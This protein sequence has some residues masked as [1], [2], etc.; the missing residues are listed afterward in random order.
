MKVLKK[1]GLMLFLIA[2]L[3]VTLT[4]GIV[5]ALPAR[6]ASAEEGSGFTPEHT[7]TVMTEKALK[8]A[9]AAAGETPTLIKLGAN[10]EMNSITS[11]GEGTKYYELI[12]E[13]GQNIRL[14][15]AGH[16]LSLALNRWSDYVIVNYGTLS[17]IDSSGNYSGKVVSNGLIESS[18]WRQASVIYN[19]GDLTV[20]ANI[21]LERPESK[22][23]PGADDYYNGVKSW[24]QSMIISGLYIPGAD[25]T[26][27][28]ISNSSVT[29]NGGTFTGE[30]GEVFKVIDAN[31][32]INDGKFMTSP[33]TDDGNMNNVYLFG[34]YTYTRDPYY[35]DD[36]YV[37][38]EGIGH[39]YE[40][41]QKKIDAELKLQKELIEKLKDYRHS[42]VQIKG[43]DFAQYTSATLKTSTNIQCCTS[44]EMDEWG[45]EYTRENLGN[46]EVTI[47]LT[48][49]RWGI[50]LSTYVP[51]GYWM[52]LYQETTQ[53]GAI[54]TRYYQVSRIDENRAG[55]LLEVNGEKHYYAT[56]T[57]ALLAA[58]KMQAET[59]TI[60]LLTDNQIGQ[61]GL[62][63]L[64]GELKL[65][66]NGHKLT[67][68]PSNTYHITGGNGAV[69]RNSFVICDG[70]DRQD[71]ELVLSVKSGKAITGGSFI[72]VSQYT[73]LV[74]ES[75]TI[76]QTGY[77]PATY[78]D[79]KNA[80]Y[81]RNCNLLS[82]FKLKD[83]FITDSN[84]DEY[85]GCVQIKGGN[86][87]SDLAF[88]TEGNVVGRRAGELFAWKDSND[89]QN[90][91]YEC[92][93]GE[94]AVSAKNKT[95]IF[96][97]DLGNYL[98][99]GTTACRF[100]WDFNDIVSPDGLAS[101]PDGNGDYLVTL[102]NEGEYF[103][104]GSEKVSTLQAALQKAKANDTIS[105]LQ[106]ATVSGDVEIG[107]GITL[108]LNS[109][110]NFK[111][112]FEGGLT[113]KEGASIKNGTVICNN[114]TVDGDVTLEAVTVTGKEG[115]T[116][117][118]VQNG[119]LTIPSGTY[120]GVFTFEGDAKAVITGGSF[121]GDQIAGLEK[122]FGKFLGGY[123]KAGESY[124][125]G[126][127][128]EVK[129][130]PNLKAQEW[131]DRYKN[132]IDKTFLIGTPEEWGYFAL[133]VNSG[134]DS[135]RGKTAKLSANLD[136]AS[137]AANGVA[138]AA[139]T[140]EPNFMPAG[141]KTNPF[142][143]TLD[144]DN[145]EISGIVA[146]EM[147][148]GLIGYATNPSEATV[149]V[150]R[151]TLK[152]SVFTVGHGFLDALNEKDD[153]T[154]AGGAIIGQSHFGTVQSDI[155]L[156]NITVDH[157]ITGYRVFN[158]AVI[159]HTF[160]VVSVEN[161]EMTGSS[162]SSDWKAGGVAGYC[163][164][165]FTL[166]NGTLSE[167]SV[168]IGDGSTGS[169]VILGHANGPKTT[170]ENCKVD[171][172]DQ[173][174]I[175]TSVPGA[176]QQR[177]KLIEITGSETDI[178]VKSLGQ[179]NTTENVQIELS[180]DEEGN[181]S[182]VQFSS[183]ELPSNL[184][185]T[186]DGNPVDLSG[187]LK[188]D[189][190]NGSFIFEA[191]AKK[192]DLYS[193]G[194]VHVGSFNTLEEALA[195]ASAGDR[196]YVNESISENITIAAGMDV[197]INLLG[198]T[199]TG[200]ITVDGGKLTLENGIFTAESGDVVTVKD[201]GK[202]IL[203]VPKLGED[204][205][206]IKEL[207]ITSK[208]GKAIEGEYT[209]ETNDNEVCVRKGES[210][211]Y[212]AKEHDHS[213]YTYTAA[214]DTI[215]VHCVH[216]GAELGTVKVVAPANTTF[217]GDAIEATVVVDPDGLVAAPAIIY[218]NAESE[219]V[220]SVVNSGVYTA[221]ITLGDV[222]ASVEF[223]VKKASVRIGGISAVKEYD[224]SAEFEGEVEEATVTLSS[225]ET[226]T[227][228]ELSLTVR[229]KLVLSDSNV[230]THTY[231]KIVEIHVTGDGTANYEV[232]P[233]GNQAFIEVKVT[234]RA[235]TVRV[236]RDGSVSYEGF[237]NGEDESVLE[238]ELH[239]ERVDNGDGTSTVT[240]SGLTSAN[241]VITFESGIV[242]NEQSNNAL[243]ITLAVVGGV[244]AALGAVAVVYAVRRKKN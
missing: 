56:F 117:V 33:Y 31:L 209:V 95:K 234:E 182:Q 142:M 228:A 24:G 42:D 230:G 215:T 216:D 105:V 197:I 5:F 193:E 188:T 168:E 207:T 110:V 152:D 112:T 159:G 160:G 169:G 164:D 238:G 138:L 13:R 145:H 44:Y 96:V 8:D 122:Y 148:V 1:Q 61:I 131:Y 165:N 180:K 90:H 30:Y 244:I 40:E 222:T 6:T 49:G 220:D 192:I 51:D 126:E 167:I 121:S 12:V 85:A 34:V 97:V 173:L 93:L 50:D 35:P 43:G 130:A 60:T 132:N 79:T 202:L 239:L 54:L 4:L 171:A 235:L 22:G 204:E 140:K 203:A 74:L 45:G 133:Y 75:G 229:V 183:E 18:R 195:K 9:V 2:A 158:G 89:Y 206:V 26:D 128:Y 47:T 196:I 92:G 86:I 237:V 83:I 242:E 155:K 65:D 214:G 69:Y 190:E 213:N 127:L 221:N 124:Q 94:G 41:D 102:V 166:K 63:D 19:Y 87:L 176:G 77:V 70:S 25:D 37:D 108:N 223:T 46:S 119:T 194:S 153:T 199:L 146:R 170:I 48:G 55:A 184:T 100:S 81:T 217:S 208:D 91:T 186:N 147:F 59:R 201:G 116:S 84:V 106:D 200:K 125:D 181:A 111:V 139:E 11:G 17:I 198:H 88:G 120:Q 162:V 151:I 29:V 28:T 53:T 179:L 163:E 185:V 149:D 177:S 14:D 72:Q 101:S 240:P 175:G 20:N 236:N 107:N 64:K 129:F 67:V 80:Q 118:T 157:D 15:L 68:E 7:E 113:L 10:I 52:E 32:T 178:H 123:I 27:Q 212:L 225:G 103:I 104:V 224:G 82:L 136:F 115:V 36:F 98:A 39:L 243:W 21:G 241:Y 137:G 227:A 174:L 71:G 76:R 231:A 189:P 143:G 161:L 3:I 150:Y 57:S 58:K 62:T 134:L 135:F 232:E 211:I 156:E 205:T 233:V 187:G 109:V 73:T 210:E 226:T 78:Y 66:L 114:I 218:K 191:D 16:K 154:L 141:N 144:G 99:D 38:D 172:P 23:D 219:V